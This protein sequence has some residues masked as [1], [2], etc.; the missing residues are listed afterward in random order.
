MCIALQI[1][2]YTFVYGQAVTQSP[3]E[4]IHTPTHM[5]RCPK[6]LALGN[7]PHL[8]LPHCTTN[9]DIPKFY[10]DYSKTYFMYVW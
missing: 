10:E 9:S 2:I 8:C 3:A 6:T 1:M 4:G 7:L 5:Y